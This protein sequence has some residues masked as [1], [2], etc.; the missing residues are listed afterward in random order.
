MA[1]KPNASTRGRAPATVPDLKAVL[2]RA[3]ACHQAGLLSEAEQLYRQILETHPRQFDCLN[4][5]GIIHYQRG[6]Y[7]EAL[8]QLDRALAVNAKIADAHNGRAA[9]LIGLK[10]FDERSEEHTSEL[11]SL[12]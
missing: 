4:L 2:S 10:R 1:H 6:V 8:R 9:A 11:Q 7:A 3:V 5:L 12:V